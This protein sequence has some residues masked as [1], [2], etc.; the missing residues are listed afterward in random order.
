MQTREI[1]M[2]KSASPRAA[3]RTSVLKQL[4][5]IDERI[6]W[7]KRRWTVS[8]RFYDF[9]APR[10]VNGNIVVRSRTESEYPENNR[11]DWHALIDQIDAATAELD[12]L[13]VHAIAMW[14]EVRS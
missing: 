14:H 3:A 11:A 6:A 4:K 8:S 2:G 7:L 1:D 12:A 5:A 10:T 9:D 13:R